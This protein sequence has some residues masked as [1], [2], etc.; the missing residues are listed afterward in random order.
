M[1]RLPTAG[2]MT[3]YDR[4]RSITEYSV[5]RTQ[6]TALPY[7]RSTTYPVLMHTPPRCLSKSV[8]HLLYPTRLIPASNITSNKQALTQPTNNI[9]HALQV[10]AYLARCV[11]CMPTH[12]RHCPFPYE[13][14]YLNTV[15]APERRGIE[16]IEIV[17]A[18]ERTF[19]CNGNHGLDCSI[20]YHIVNTEHILYIHNSL[21]GQLACAPKSLNIFH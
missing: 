12:P 2:S 15:K 9:D 4:S 1:T 16:K 3:G 14:L 17:S 5:L 8:R 21:T 20:I 10:C 19:H 7:V 18:R 11:P 6:A 13:Q